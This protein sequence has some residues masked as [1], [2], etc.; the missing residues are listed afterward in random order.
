MIAVEVRLKDSVW[1]SF[2]DTDKVKIHYWEWFTS[3][4]NSPTPHR[5]VSLLQVG[6]CGA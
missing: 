1:L 6:L 2:S 4:N 5:P 3:K